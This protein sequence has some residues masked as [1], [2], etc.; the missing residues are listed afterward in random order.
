[1]KVKEIFNK[2]CLKKRVIVYEETFLRNN[3]SSYRVDV[4][5]L[6]KRG[7]ETLKEQI[8]FNNKEASLACAKMILN[9]EGEL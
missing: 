4:Y 1:M 6:G 2:G 9:R 8:P 3:E 7:H 5:Q